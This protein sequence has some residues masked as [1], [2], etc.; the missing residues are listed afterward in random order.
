MAEVTVRVGGRS[1]A[2]ACKPGGEGRIAA[3]ASA[4]DEETQRLTATLGPM[5]EGQLLLAA[6][7]NLADR[8]QRAEAGLEEAAASVEALAALLEAAAG[9]A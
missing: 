1:Y 7:L 8:L 2:L 9:E 4:V 5:A 3:L 6:A